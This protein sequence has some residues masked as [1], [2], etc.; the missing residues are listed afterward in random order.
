M[1][2][3]CIIPAR[4]NSKGVPKKNI[5]KIMGKPLIAYT[6]EKSIKSNIFSHVIVSTEDK[7]IWCK[8]SVYETKILS[9]R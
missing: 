9:H 8:S 1:K 3:I 4:G 2:P 5:R 7:K 6:I